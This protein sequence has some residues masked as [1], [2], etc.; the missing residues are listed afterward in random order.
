MTFYTTCA[1]L[2]GAQVVPIYVK[3]NKKML[4]SVYSFWYNRKDIKYKK[5]QEN[6]K[7]FEKNE[8]HKY[9]SCFLNSCFI[10]ICILSKDFLFLIFFCHLQYIQI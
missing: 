10:F 7:L 4:Q 9:F 3:N 5:E 8:L 2:G 1:T 6:E